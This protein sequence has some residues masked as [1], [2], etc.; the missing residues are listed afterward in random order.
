[1]KYIASIA[2][3]AALTVG[4][5]LS[6]ALPTMA[7][8]LGVSPA[9]PPNVILVQE[10]GSR[11]HPDSDYDR[12]SYWR[13][14]HHWRDDEERDWDRRHWNRGWH[15]GWYDDRPYYHRHHGG[16]MLEIRP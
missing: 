2:L 8:P 13:A 9:L 3:T 11:W 15:R 16:V 6:V 1:M 4:S 5:L 10:Q 12:R 14:R 7:A